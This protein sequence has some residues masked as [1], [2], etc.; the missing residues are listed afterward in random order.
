MPADAATGRCITLQLQHL[1][2]RRVRVKL[3]RSTDV[4]HVD[5][6]QA[7]CFGRLEMFTFLLDRGAGVWSAE[8]MH[9]W[10]QETSP[11]PQSHSS[12]RQ[13]L[14]TFAFAWPEP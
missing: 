5:A 4:R 10:L 11:P 3:E 13:N 9:A 1:V 7:S 12:G 8:A 6:L 14:S 2:I